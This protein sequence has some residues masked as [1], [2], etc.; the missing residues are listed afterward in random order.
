MKVSI[1][2]RSCLLFVLIG[3]LLPSCQKEVD[4]PTITMAS[5]TGLY[6][7]IT[8]HGTYGEKKGVEYS[9]LEI[10][11]DTHFFLGR[12]YFPI[13]QTIANSPTAKTI[14]PRTTN[15]GYP[16]YAEGTSEA[17]ILVSGGQVEVLTTYH[18]DGQSWE[19]ISVYYTAKPS[20]TTLT[21]ADYLGTYSGAITNYNG[22]G[23]WET[24]TIEAD[25]TANGVWLKEINRSGFINAQGQ[26]ELP[27]LDTHT[28]VVD[29][30]PQ[31]LYDAPSVSTLK[32]KA[33]VFGIQ[34][35]SGL[36]SGA[37]YNDYRN[38]AFRKE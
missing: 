38:Y 20:A 33:L 27:R 19:S 14:I 32:G 18:L 15:L 7:N 25:S 26:L 36:P 1:L 12:A 23:N 24:L 28:S 16:Y 11:R 21:R 8:S 6:F 17:Q 3:L 30:V 22:V 2:I 31:V 5:D 4:T 35:M 13:S 34:H 10:V 37:S 29:G 9:R